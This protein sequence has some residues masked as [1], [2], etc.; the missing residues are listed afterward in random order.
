M[1]DRY[2]ELIAQRDYA[3]QQYLDAKIAMQDARNYWSMLYDDCWEMEHREPIT[4]PAVP[5]SSPSPD[6][7]ASEPFPA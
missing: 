6:S 3:Y 5:A 7:V 2:I 1:N 4:P